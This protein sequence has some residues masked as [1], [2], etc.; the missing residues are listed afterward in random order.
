[1]VGFLCSIDVD[2]S[3]F[4]ANI[5]T[6]QADNNWNRIK[7][8]FYMNDPDMSEADRAFINERLLF[9]KNDHAFTLPR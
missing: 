3:L 8:R 4:A 7:P 5:V 2:R 6:E 9:L 1:M